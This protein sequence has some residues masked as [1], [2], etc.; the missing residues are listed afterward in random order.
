MKHIFAEEDRVR[1]TVMRDA[2]DPERIYVKTETDERPTVEA[3]QRIRSA[4]MMRQDSR[5]PLVEGDVIAFAFSFPT[6]TDYNLLRR[7][8]PELFDA[9]HRGD[10]SERMRA[11]ERLS[12]LYP[13]YVTTTK[14]GDARRGR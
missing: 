4:D 3:N 2:H 1:K 6:M 10:Y 7:K 9:V 13:Q 5:N 12:I 8:E 14:R 11:A